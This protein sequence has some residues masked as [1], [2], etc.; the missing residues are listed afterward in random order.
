MVAANGPLSKK[1]F[2]P[3]PSCGKFFSAD[4]GLKYHTSQSVC[5]G[6]DRVRSFECGR[7]GRAFTSKGG[8]RYHE[9]RCG[10]RLKPKQRRKKPKVEGVYDQVFEQL[11]FVKRKKG[12]AETKRKA[13]PKVVN[14]YSGVYDEVFK[15][16]G[17][18]TGKAKRKRKASKAARGEDEGE[19]GVTPTPRGIAARSKKRGKKGEESSSENGSSPYEI[20]GDGFGDGSYRYPPVLLPP[21]FAVADRRKI[22]RYDGG[23][24]WDSE[25]C[26]CGEGGDL[27]CCEYCNRVMHT[28]CFTK[29]GYFRFGEEGGDG[30]DFMCCFCG[31]DVMKLAAS[32][33]WSK[34]AKLF[35]DGRSIDDLEKGPLPPKAPPTAEVRKGQKVRDFPQMHQYL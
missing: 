31:D 1:R 33:K 30:E 11:G 9:E 16:M 14:K 20:P 12:G 17:F 35:V 27:L 8:L 19:E 2:G 7:C 13:P 6:T 21:L 28:D 15:M 34:E 18:V 4:F 5:S 3:C 32:S 10:V 26:L 25:C 22:P 23:K 29:L 24:G